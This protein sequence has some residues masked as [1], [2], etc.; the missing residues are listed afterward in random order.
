MKRKKTFQVKKKIA[1]VAGN[2]NL[3]IFVVK[4]LITEKR[5]F[6]IL[7]FDKNN[8]LFFKKLLNKQTNKIFLVNLK[9]I[10]NILLI[11]KREK[12][13]QA[14]CCGGVKF[15]G[16][17]N[18]NILNLKSFFLNYKILF[19]IV[20]VLFSK[21][22]GDDFLLTLVEKILNSINCKIIAVQ[23]ILPDL[24]CTK[25]D[26]INKTLTNKYKKDIYYGSKILDTLSPYDIG[27]SIVIHDGRVLGIEGA[28]GTQNLIKRCRKYLNKN[29]DKRKPI[30]VK[31]IKTNQNLKLDIPTIGSET[32]ENLIE[33]NFAGLAIQNKNV[34]I[35]DKDKVA[36]LCKK[37]NLFLF[38]ID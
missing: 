26:E 32:I 17:E 24:L 2:G 9:N 37:N 5:D 22:K 31:K 16:L 4:K 29:L 28:E 14:I 7:C 36:N 3:P 23:N 25:Q 38:I 35:L 20:K 30:L 1:V 6:I 33:N 15:I 18:L 13:H 8:L 19:Y 11:L 27:Q 21:Q 12:I 34:F 10:S